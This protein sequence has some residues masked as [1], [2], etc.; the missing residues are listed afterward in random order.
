[1]SVEHDES[2]MQDVTIPL[3]ELEQRVEK[4]ENSFSAYQLSIVDKLVES[5]AH[6]FNQ[7]IQIYLPKVSKQLDDLRL[8]KEKL[9]LKMKTWNRQE[10]QT[11]QATG[12]ID[13][14][15]LQSMNFAINHIKSEIEYQKKV[16]SVTKLQE[17]DGLVKK[18]NNITY[19]VQVTKMNMENLATKSELDA[20]E[21][22]LMNYAPL[23]RL[24]DIQEDICDFVKKEE[25]NIIAREMDYLKKDM[26][27]LVSKEEI[28]TRLNV[29]NSD[30]NT[31]MMDRPTITY[32]KKVL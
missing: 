32:F 16:F 3:F 30:I 31:K 7:Q 25:Y 23:Q 15:Q 22:S 5:V 17:I 10:E 24:T 19:D 14:S 8:F 21:R 12:S 26:S 29:F 20:T 28:M 13:A 9:E 2:R 4:L 27:K 6:K 18:V 11:E 1:M